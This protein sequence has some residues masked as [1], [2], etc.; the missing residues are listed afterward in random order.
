LL[1]GSPRSDSTLNWTNPL[2]LDNAAANL[3]AAQREIRVTLGTAVPEDKTRFTA[4]I[5][6][7]AAT[8]LLKTGTGVLELAASNTYAG[9]TL[10]TGGTLQL[11]NGSTG[12][13]TG[14]G[15][16]KVFAGATLGGSGTALPATGN[17]VLIAGTVAPGDPTSPQGTL[18]FGSAATPT[19]VT[20][21]GTG[22]Y[23]ASIGSLGNSDLL[24][25]NGQLSLAPGS[26]LS[27]AGSADGS[28]YVLATYS[29]LTGSF[30][31][32]NNLPTGYFISY[33]TSAITLTP[34][35]EPGHVLLACGLA[36]T[37]LGWWRRRANTRRV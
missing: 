18:T 25:V 21:D 9:N 8:D 37:G 33:G 19:T 28:S 11:G 20:I 34:V 5:G 26:T 14:S 6:G 4:P 15:S 29:G 12:S 16:V 3:P 23:F 22:A 24:G 2:H 32:V 10:V 27:I 1:F 17:G 35:P 13:A 30:T 36:A 31:A 7:S